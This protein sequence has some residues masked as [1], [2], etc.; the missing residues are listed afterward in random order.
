MKV[1]FI[2]DLKGKGRVNDIKEES[3]GYAVNF[4]IKNG[5]AAAY[6]KGS[7][8]KLDNQ[9]KEKQELDAKNV[10]EAN[11][12]KQR[13]EKETIK[14]VVKTGKD[15]RVFGSI[16]SKQIADE[17]NKKE[18]KIDKK[19]IY[20]KNTINTLGVHNVEVSLHK[21]VIANLKIQLTDK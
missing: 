3:D 20:I 12:I 2:K 8:Q 18:Y 9:I 15:G 7:A 16:S 11:K 19:N 21:K 17:L 1:I 4:L 10:E 13:I 6:T 5:Y 14:F